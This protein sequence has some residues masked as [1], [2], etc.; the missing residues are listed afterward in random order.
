[1]LRPIV[2]VPTYNE[3]ENVPVLLARIAAVAP[4]I[5]VLIVDDQSPDGTAEAALSLAGAYPLLQVMTRTGPRGLGLAYVE[6][7]QR[8]LGEGYGPVVQMDADLSHDPVHLPQLFAAARTYD[9]VIGSR[10]CRDGAVRDWPVRRIL[11]SRL[12]NCYVRAVTGVPTADATAGYRC[13]SRRALEAVDL[14]TVQSKGYAFQ[15]EMAYRAHRSGMRITEAP[16]TFCD[17]TRGSSK[18][19]GRVIS[20]AILV[21]WRLRLHGSL[22]QHAVV[23]TARPRVPR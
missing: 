23:S 8:V 5:A 16:I 14:P 4:D 12:A 6:A 2:V 11:L 13:W 22:H 7:F 17:R 18:M 10:Y 3:V 21:P 1:M 20:E 9:L 19:S 15:I